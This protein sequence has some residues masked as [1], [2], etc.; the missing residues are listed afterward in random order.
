MMLCHNGVKSIDETL[1][2]ANFKSLCK[3]IGSQNY[4]E[5]IEEDAE[6]FFNDGRG[7]DSEAVLLSSEGIPYIETQ[8]QLAHAATIEQY[9]KVKDNPEHACVSCHRLFVKDGVTKFQYH[10]QKF[11]SEVWQRLKKFMLHSG[12]DVK[13]KTL[14]VCEY[15]RTRL[16]A[17]ELPNR[18][19]LNGL[20]TVPIP[21][22]VSKLN[23]LERQLI[24]K[25]K[26]FPT[27][28]RPGTYTSKVPIYSATNTIKGTSFF[29]PMPFDKTQAL[30]DSINMPQDLASEVY[31]ILPDPHVFILLDGKPAKDKVVWQSMVDVDNVKEAVQ[32]LKEINWLYKNTDEVCVGDVIKTI[33]YE[34]FRETSNKLL[35][36]A[37]EQDILAL[38]HYTIHH[39]SESMPV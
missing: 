20:L 28:I 31:I 19:I 25:T 35:E 22:Y 9:H 37:I 39:I 8:L 6:M 2:A 33:F 32:R 10:I 17:N 23:I 15:C 16:N 38:D 13:D 29:L 7:K 26:A 3:L 30:L 14:Y 11:K 24:Q 1:H 34:T 18:C 21:N 36:K 12:P 4:T 5:L 27:I